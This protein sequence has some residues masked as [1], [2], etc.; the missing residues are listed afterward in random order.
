MSKPVTHL[1]LCLLVLQ[2]NFYLGQSLPPAIPACII[3]CQTAAATCATACLATALAVVVCEAGCVIVYS[4]CVAGCGVACFHPNT[5]VGLPDGSTSV[6]VS[7]LAVGQQLID[8]EFSTKDER[9]TSVTKV[10]E[11]DGN[12]EYV[13]IKLA[14]HTKELLVTTDHVVIA[15]S[16][17]VPAS[18]VQVGDVLIVSDE[19]SGKFKEVNVVS[20]YNFMDTKKVNVE[21]TTG[22]MF[23][24]GVLTTVICDG[25]EDN[26][27]SDVSEFFIAYDER[28]EQF[29]KELEQKESQLLLS[30]ADKH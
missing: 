25:Y 9:M 15:N 27:N 13:G 23:A 5:T 3:G 26:L 17:V 16:K 4:G 28:H 22:T 12:F 20:I 6:G 19:T 8:F 11:L 7:N 29:T 24:N 14:D 10:E 30:F 2:H 21:T 18:D 1:I